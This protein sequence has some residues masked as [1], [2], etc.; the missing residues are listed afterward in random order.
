MYLLDTNVVSALGPGRSTKTEPLADWLRAKTDLLF[1]SV[2]T[3]AELEA[4][5]AKLRRNGTERKAELIGAWIEAVLALF[6]ARVLAFGIAEARIAG[7][8]HDRARAAGID[9]GFADVAIAAT[10]SQHGLLILTRNTR[11]FSALGVP[12]HDPFK[13]LPP[14]APTDR[15]RV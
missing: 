4:G 11:H 14:D 1:L 12:L 3:I 8:L 6:G 10:A 15:R 9:P 2:V 7:A 13:A 5:V